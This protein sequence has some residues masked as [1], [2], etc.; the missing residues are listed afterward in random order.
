M[1]DDPRSFWAWGLTERLPDAAAR[2]ALARRVGAALGVGDLPD[3]P[4][5]DIDAVSLRPPRV[6]APASL[7][8]FVTDARE[9]RL[10]HTY[11]RGW[12]DILRALQGDF[13]PAPDLVAYPRDEAEVSAAMAWCAE[14]GAA[15]V[16]WGGGT[17]VVGGVEAEVS[18]RWAGAL[19]LDLRR[20][21]RVHDVD[22]ANLTSRIGAG[23]TGPAIDAALA[24]SGHT[25]RHYPQSYEFST[26]GGWIAT[27]AG[28]HFATGYTRIDDRVQSVRVVSPS[29][30][31][32]TPAVPSSGAGPDPKRLALGSEGALGV[33]TEAVVRVLPRPRWRR[34]ASARFDAMEQAVSAARAVAQSGLLPSNCRVL[35]P[36]EAFINRVDDAAGG[37][38]LLLGFESADHDPESAMARALEIALAHGGE[39]PRGVLARDDA[40]DDGSAAAQWRRAFLDGP[41]LQ[42]ALA[43]VGVMAD[44]F[45]TC[46]AWSAFEAL[47]RDVVSAVSEALA[48]HCGGGVV[49]C[50]FTHVYP[51]G[52]APYYSFIGRYEPSRALAQWAAVKRAASDALRAHGATITHH[53]AVGRT[54]RPWYDGERP[55]L[56]ADALRAVKRTLDPAGVM[57]P[58]VLLRE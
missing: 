56:F 43:L 20:M 8:G 29:G 19:A 37:A 33:I 30:A 4:P 48:E 52:P 58:G 14:A 28:G 49:S 25:L 54:H 16:P 36:T 24:R 10:R 35:D 27:R 12:R 41:Y 6:R 15:L 2:R 9:D 11:G 45:E 44:T 55:A 5:P 31:W 38:A 57:N 17:S 26:L 42:S 51:D 53:H 18:P 32:E 7:A 40:G 22:V 23:A 39:C 34:S 3:I 47:H 13:S 21:A 1:S 50:R 46:C